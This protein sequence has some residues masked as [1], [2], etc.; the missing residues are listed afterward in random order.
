MSNET[1][2]QDKTTFEVKKPRMYKVIIYNDDYTT[3]DFVVEVLVS[4][5]LKDVPDAVK[6]M[7]NVHKNGSG[8]AGIYSY[9]IAATKIKQTQG[10][11]DKSGYPLKLTL[12]GV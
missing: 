4:V 12:E 3:M 5:F 1:K 9:D 8:V 10:M 6:I 2:L 7:F 11:A